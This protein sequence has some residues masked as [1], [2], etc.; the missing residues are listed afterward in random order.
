M[1]PI[2]HF[3]TIIICIIRQSGRKLPDIEKV[4]EAVDTDSF[5]C[6]HIVELIPFLHDIDPEYTFAL[7]EQLLGST[8]FM[9]GWGHGH[10][11]LSAYAGM[12]IQKAEQLALKFLNSKDVNNQCAGCC[13]L[14]GSSYIDK[15]FTRD[16]VWKGFQTADEALHTYLFPP[17]AC[18]IETDLPF[19]HKVENL[20]GSNRRFKSPFYATLAGC[21]ILSGAPRDNLERFYA[22][23]PSRNAEDFWNTFNE[24]LAVT[25][26]GDTFLFMLPRW[27]SNYAL[28]NCKTTLGFDRL[29][30]MFTKKDEEGLT[31]SS[32]SIKYLY[33]VIKLDGFLK[34][35]PASETIVSQALL[36]YLQ[37]SS[38]SGDELV[39]HEAILSSLRFP[40][41]ISDCYKRFG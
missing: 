29:R 13:I 38:R 14:P 28:N 32:L 7:V 18:I 22:D 40:A 16:I 9:F 21:Y 19:F 37:N 35:F 6:E 30:M 20:L 33:P 17:L 36:C 34:R 23:D 11:M 1:K 3:A 15:E 25:A 8:S 27:N 12:N 5:I 26:K 10:K 4:R 39:K 24:Q 41:L 31:Q 2:E